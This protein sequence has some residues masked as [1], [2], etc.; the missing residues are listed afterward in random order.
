[1]I[2]WVAIY[3]LGRSGAVQ[4]SPQVRALAESGKSPSTQEPG[5][6]LELCG[7]HHS[8]SFFTLI[9]RMGPDKSDNILSIYDN[10]HATISRNVQSVRRLDQTVAR[11]AI[12]HCHTLL[13][14]R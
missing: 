7:T 8:P 6:N 5:S 14:A 13:I 10:G 3:N 2:R 12:Y 11:S 1:M 9:R 4:V